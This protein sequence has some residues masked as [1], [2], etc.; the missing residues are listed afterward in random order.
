ME[1]HTVLRKQADWHRLH[2]YQKSN[3]LYLMTA[4]FTHRFLPPHGDRTVDQ[5]VQAARSGKQNIVEGTAD[6]VTSTEMELKLLNVA[7][8]SIQELREDYADY[9]STHGDRQWRPN[10]PRYD[11]MLRFCRRH[12][13]AQDY[14]PFLNRWS[15]E[16]MAN[17]A[18][19]L[20]RQTD[21]MMTTYLKGLEQRFVTEGGIKERMHAARTGYR[22][23]VDRR[24]WELESE[25]QALK[26]ENERLRQQLNLPPR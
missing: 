16:E 4:V 26:A 25:N 14:Q 10:H 15:D 19:T 18:L 23:G 2:F 5:M 21:K 24:L 22:D 17:V 6:G 12:N 11:S 1:P 20:C 8:A 13:S 7:R 9:L 3:A